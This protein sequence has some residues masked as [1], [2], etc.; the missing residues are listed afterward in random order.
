MHI[1][2]VDDDERCLASIESFLV[3]EGHSIYTATHGEGAVAVAR[4]VRARN[5]RI[6]VSI[7]DYRMPDLTGVETYLQ[8]RVE[9]P[10]LGAIFVSGEPFSTLRRAFAALEDFS[11]V[12]KPLKLIE[13]RKVLYEFERRD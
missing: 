4:R 13:V 10:A 5:E 9:F 1:L 12:Q 6:D 3:E 11:F 8:L 7:L 2:V